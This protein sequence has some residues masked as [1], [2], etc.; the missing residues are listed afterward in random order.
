MTPENGG[1]WGSVEGTRDVMNWTQADAAYALAKANGFP[2]KWHTLVWG[3]QQPNW[4]DDLPPA[5]QLE[6]IREWYAAIAARYPDID[7]IEVVNE[8]L[9]DPPCTRANGGGG[10][11]DALGGRGTAGTRTGLGLGSSSRSSWRVSTSRT[12]S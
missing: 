8:P 5:E 11:I 9:H 2:F 12:R 4:I 7:Q 1:K 3:N 6:E 10:Y